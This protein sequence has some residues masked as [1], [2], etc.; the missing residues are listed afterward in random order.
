M[1]ESLIWCLID[2]VCFRQSENSNWCDNI[3]MDNM[4]L[5]Y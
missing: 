5:I 4:D 3:C 2:C 1:L